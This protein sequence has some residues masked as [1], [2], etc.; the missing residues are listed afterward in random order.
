LGPVPAFVTVL[1]TVRSS[2][3]RE[4]C[5]QPYEVILLS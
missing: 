5:A 3:L 4:S 2:E 1:M